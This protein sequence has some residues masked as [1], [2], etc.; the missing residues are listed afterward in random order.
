MSFSFHFVRAKSVDTSQLTKYMHLSAPKTYRNQH[1]EEKQQQPPI[2]PLFE[3]KPTSPTKHSRCE[4]E[5]E[6]QPKQHERKS[7]RVSQ[8][9]RTYVPQKEE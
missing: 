4:H 7:T 1:Q 3:P 8:P 6:S 5:P 2:P 9:P